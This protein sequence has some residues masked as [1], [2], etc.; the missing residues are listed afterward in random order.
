MISLEGDLEE[1]AFHHFVIY[2]SKSYTWEH[3]LS[4]FLK[5]LYIIYFMSNI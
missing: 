1:K 4:K 5:N 3:L 2:I